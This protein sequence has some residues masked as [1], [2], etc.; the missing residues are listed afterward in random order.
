[1]NSKSRQSIFSKEDRPDH[2]PILSDLMRTPV[3][4]KIKI[5]NKIKTFT[6]HGKPPILQICFIAIKAQK[7]TKDETKYK[8]SIF[9]SI[10]S[11]AMMTRK[12]LFC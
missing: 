9:K 4:Q 6:K 12:L 2:K 11:A 10:K 3:G 8:N 1:M 7:N 5:K